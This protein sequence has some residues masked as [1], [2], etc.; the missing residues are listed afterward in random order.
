MRLGRTVEEHR[1]EFLEAFTREGVNRR[2]VCRAYD[3]APKTAYGLLKRYVQEGED[4]LRERSRRPLHSPARLDE[5][6]ERRILEIRG[7]YRW[8]PRKIRWKLEQEGGVR[9]PARS[10]IEAVLRRHGQI[11]PERSAQSRPFRRFEYEAANDLWQMDFK[12]HFGMG[13]GKRCHPLVIL[14]DHSR[15]MIELHACA[16]ER[17][18][19]V[20]QRLVGRFQEYG[21]PKRILADNGP[22]WGSAGTRGYTEIEVWLMQLGVR[23]LHGRW[24][25]PQTQGKLERSNRTLG[26]EIDLFRPDAKARRTG[27]NFW[28]TRAAGPLRAERGYVP[29]ERTYPERLPPVEY[30]SR[31]PVR[32]VQMGGWIS[33]AG[34]AWRVGKAFRGKQVAVVPA[35]KEGKLNVYFGRYRIAELDL[36]TGRAGPL[37]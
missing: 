8:G 25:H 10:T 11:D 34:R 3:V 33:Y 6:T 1:R 26:V 5:A 21:L 37:D 31:V 35:K 32:R 4:A 14:D 28:S 36:R 27:A 7:Q 17:R 18:A 30:E 16:D 29:S 9:V 15:Y 20:H 23:V 24:R 2:A 13:D 12:G 22:P 19:T